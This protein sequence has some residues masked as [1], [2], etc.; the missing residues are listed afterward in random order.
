MTDLAAMAKAARAVASTRPR[1]GVESAAANIAPG[2]GAALMDRAEG[3]VRKAMG[4]G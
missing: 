2:P 4:K 1:P 3:A